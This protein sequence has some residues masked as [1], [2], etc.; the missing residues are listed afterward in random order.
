MLRVRCNHYIGVL[1]QLPL[2][3]D[4]AVAAG[5][6]SQAACM[7][8]ATASTAKLL[9]DAGYYCGMS[10]GKGRWTIDILFKCPAQAHESLKIAWANARATLPR[11]SCIGQSGS[12]I[13]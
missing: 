2:P 6:P 4:A 13:E 7:D 10:C 5:A 9:I 8:E 3:D 11:M 12:Y 1:L